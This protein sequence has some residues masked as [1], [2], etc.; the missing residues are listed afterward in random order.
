MKILTALLAVL[1]PVV[2]GADAV[3]DEGAARALTDSIM[4][5]WRLA[6]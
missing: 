2:A 6:T 1:I 5:K 4:T 3:K